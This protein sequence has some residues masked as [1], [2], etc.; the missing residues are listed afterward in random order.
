MIKKTPGF[1]M[2]EMMIVLVVLVILASIAYPSYQQAIL[3]AK[4]SE[5]RAALT[6]TMQQQERYYSIYTSYLAFSSDSTGTN[7]KKFKW[8][9]G[10]NAS[11][12][13]YEI[14]ARAC[15][16]ENIRDC[17]L[18][19]AQPGTIKVIPDYRDPLCGN[20]TLNSKG[21]RSADADRCWQ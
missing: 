19:I 12:S 9:S 5:G 11:S 18:L 2:I 21:E 15:D 10:E 20:L 17:V 8:F 4:R 14:S 13:L 1:T 6:R 3:K 16:G 7:E